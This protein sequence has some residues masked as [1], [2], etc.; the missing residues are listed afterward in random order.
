MPRAGFFSHFGLL[1]VRDFLDAGLCARLR[2]ETLAA[3][4]SPATIGAATEDIVN[5]SVRRA[6]TAKVSSESRLLIKSRLSDIQPRLESHFDLALKGFEKPQFLVYSQGGF[7][8]PHQDSSDSPDAAEYVKARKVSVTIFL[9]NESEEPRQDSYVGGKL[10]FYGLMEDP[11]WK[12]CGLPLIGEE[13]LLI[14]F[15]SD[16]T[17]EVT[18]VT[19]GA[20]SVVSWFF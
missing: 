17:H 10:T 8:T 6:G 15:R 3:V 2:A 19:H 14:A 1:A 18:P 5:E 9:N 13:G 20:Y 11:L 16:I 4:V 12:S 7:Y